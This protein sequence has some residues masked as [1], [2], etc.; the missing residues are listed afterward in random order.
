M[1]VMNCSARGVSGG[2]HFDLKRHITEGKVDFYVCLTHFLPPLGQF[3]YFLNSFSSSFGFISLLLSPLF[4]VSI[5]AILDG[6]DCLFHLTA[7]CSVICCSVIASAH[8]N[9]TADE[10]E[11]RPQRERR[12]VRVTLEEVIFDWELVFPR[13][14]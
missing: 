13:C 5:E 12:D 8:D 11:R 2:T 4:S 9:E 3:S 7:F 14:D 6:R 10:G 1:S